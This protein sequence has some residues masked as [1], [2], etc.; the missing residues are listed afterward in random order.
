LLTPSPTAAPCCH[1]RSKSCS[2]PASISVKHENKFSKLQGI[3]T[4]GRR[5]EYSYSRS[6]EVRLD[7]V[8]DGTGVTDY[9]IATLLGLGTDSVANQIDKFLKLCFRMDGGIHE[10]KYLKIQWG[11]GALKDFDCRLQSV[12]IEYTL[13]DKS[14]APLH[15]VLKTNFIEDLGPGQAHPPGWQEFARPVA[16]A[17]G[18][19]RRYPAL[20][21][22]EIYGSSAYYLRVAQ[23][24]NIDDFRN[25][26]P[27][28]RLSSRSPGHTRITKWINEH[29]HSHHHQQGY[30]Q[31]YHHRNEHQV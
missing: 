11:D 12:D 21:T 3:N 15:A 4:S 18:E 28:Q 30:G 24:N 14:G 2:N 26:N 8:L 27:G 31:E 19:E 25:L 22:K 29:R 7:L 6:K 10:P 1:L 20:L 9:G 23:V 16:Y 5:A 17:G 13:F